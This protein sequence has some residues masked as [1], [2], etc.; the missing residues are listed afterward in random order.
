MSPKAAVHVAALVPIHNADR[1]TVKL[2][3]NAE[4]L[5]L[6]ERSRQVV[7]VADASK[8]GRVAFAQICPVDRVHELITDV[9]AAPELVA[10]L[11]D[12]GIRVTTV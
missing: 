1:E 9:G 2:S 11:E 3:T 8:L 12:S 7:V 5:A 10:G 4:F 6:I